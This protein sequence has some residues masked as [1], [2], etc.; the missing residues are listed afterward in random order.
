MIGS[1]G[2]VGVIL[3]VGLQYLVVCVVS[4]LYVQRRVESIVLDWEQGLCLGI[5]SLI[6]SKV[7]V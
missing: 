4:G 2:T 7:F 3:K 1:K 6:G 5:Q